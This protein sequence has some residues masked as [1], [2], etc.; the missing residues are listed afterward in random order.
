MNE[1]SSDFN[2]P[3]GKLTT[4]YKL[5]YFGA[6]ILSLGFIFIAAEVEVAAIIFIFT[7]IVILIA[8]LVFFYIFLYRLWKF[9]IPAL[10][11]EGLKPSIN[12]PAEAIGFMFIPVF[13]FYWMFKAIGGLPKEIHNLARSKN[14]QPLIS[15]Q[16]GIIICVLV[17]LSFIPYLGILISAVLLLV[18]HPILLRDC[19]KDCE[20]IIA[21]IDVQTESISYKPSPKIDWESF[22][23]YS[24]LFNKKEYGINYFV[25]IAF[26]VGLVISRLIRFSWLDLYYDYYYLP[27]FDFMLIGFSIDL[28]FA[29]I[30]VL[31]SHLV[32]QSWFLPIFGGA[33]YFLISI[34]HTVII[35]KTMDPTSSLIFSFELIDP[36][37]IITDFI[38]GF[39]FFV[40]IVFAVYMW[41]AKIW[42]LIIGFSASYLINKIIREGIYSIS[43]SSEFGIDT[44]FHG[45]DLINIIAKLIMAALIY[46][47][48]YLHFEK[49]I[50]SH[51]LILEKEG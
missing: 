19:V 42:S 43:S 46:F 22:K 14:I 28:V 36:I 17:F 4:Y 21:A 47:G 1:T 29:G 31:I 49:L 5:V 45:T 27:E 23:E 15:E 24:D 38:Y 8:A 18:L 41:G 20:R 6:G 51:N 2:S 9:L 25:G 40:G 35:Q 10:I 11:S 7:G 12:T 50:G 32:K 30:F 44:F 48:F 34:L 39:T 33:A 26:F 13:N 16:F 3:F 37:K